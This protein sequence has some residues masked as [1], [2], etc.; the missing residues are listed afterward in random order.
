[1]AIGVLYESPSIT[2][3][4]YDKIIELLQ[5]KTADGRIFHVAGPREGGGWRVVDVFESP[6]QF[7]TFVQKLVPIVQ[8]AGAEPPQV[9]VWPLH[10]MLNGPEHRR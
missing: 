9:T 10:N 2:Q 1:M 8:E 5:N 4:Q 7:E 3:E 6:A